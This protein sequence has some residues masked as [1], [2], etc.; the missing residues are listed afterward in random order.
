MCCGARSNVLPNA[1][2]DRRARLGAWG[3]L[4][5][6]IG[7]ALAIDQASKAWVIAS[8][9]LGETIVPVV[10]LHPF[11]MITH[12]RNTGAA[13]GLFAGVGDLFVVIA[14]VVTIGMLLYFPRVPVRARLTQVA[15]GLVIAGA[16]GNAIDRVVHGAVI[17]FIHYTVPGVVSNVSNLADHAIVGGVLVLVAQSWR[18]GDRRS[19]DAPSADDANPL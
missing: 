14:I 9:P 1:D 16:L 7:L 11:F 8:L 6:V 3:V 2:S 5:L 12:V 18:A 19:P 10:A 4:A 13:F 15:M 17:D